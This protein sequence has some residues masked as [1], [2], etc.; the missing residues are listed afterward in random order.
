[1][2]FNKCFWIPVAF[3]GAYGLLYP[4]ITDIVGLKDTRHLTTVLV[5]TILV[6]MLCGASVGLV[7]SYY[8]K[9]KTRK[10]TTAG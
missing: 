7:W 10:T 8:D 1:M 9:R 4:F 3:G 6:G 5:I 2:K